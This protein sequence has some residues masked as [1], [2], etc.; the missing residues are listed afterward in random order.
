MTDPDAERPPFGQ[1]VK[2]RVKQLANA[3]DL[4]NAVAV[5]TRRVDKAEAKVDRWGAVVNRLNVTHDVLVHQMT[6]VERRMDELVLPRAAEAAVPPAAAPSGDP[7]VA[8][9]QAILAEIRAE[10]A[11][12]RVRLQLLSEYEERIRRLEAAV[13]AA[14]PTS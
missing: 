2:H 10:H 6:G 8:E 4:A 13:M 14:K 9:A 3:G 11:R 12:V 5:L 1:R 7:A